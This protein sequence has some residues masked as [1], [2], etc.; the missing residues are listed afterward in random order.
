MHCRPRLRYI[1]LLRHKLGIFVYNLCVLGTIKC[2][3]FLFVCLFVCLFFCFFVFFL[4]GAIPSD[5][6]Q[7]CKIRRCDFNS[8]IT[9]PVY[10]QNHVNYILGHN[11]LAVPLRG[12][13]CDHNLIAIKYAISHLNSSLVL[14]INLGW[15]NNIHIETC[16]IY[17]QKINARFS[18]ERVNYNK[19]VCIVKSN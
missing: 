5:W 2:L 13:I 19:K 1:L 16:H 8:C 10:W 9:Q 6:I 4:G 17:C 11:R 7:I 18:S 14:L 12:A 3:V 15:F